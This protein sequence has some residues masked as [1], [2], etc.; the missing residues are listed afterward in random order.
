MDVGP[1]KVRK[2]ATS[3]TTKY[4]LSFE[5]DNTD[6]NTLTTFFNT[7]INDG[8]DSFDMSDPRNGGTETFRIIGSPEISALTGVWFRV[9]VNMEILP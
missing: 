2:R 7:T 6:V 4:Q 5:M 8:A 9:N 3:A 1:A